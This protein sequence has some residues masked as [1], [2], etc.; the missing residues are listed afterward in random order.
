MY[1]IPPMD[2]DPPPDFVVAVAA[3]E[4]ELRPEAL[5][6][7]GGDPAGHEIYQEALVDLAGHW[8]RVRLLSRV[9][10][11]DE[12]GGYLRKRIL[13]RTKAWR[14]DQL[15]PVEV[16]V[17]RTPERQ[18]VQVGGPG[19]SIALRKAAIIEGTARAGLLTLADATVAW[20]HAWRRAEHR[21]VARLII[22]GLAL[23]IAMIQSMTWLASGGS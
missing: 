14:D 21:R 7:T 15:Y 1:L 12:A 18:L 3:H 5:R 17:L 9:T 22:G 13:R 4:G 19:A 23:V 16:R 11:T 6:L 2:D 20:C 10:H 8:R